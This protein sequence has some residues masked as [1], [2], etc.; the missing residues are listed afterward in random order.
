MD[1]FIPMTLSLVLIS[2]LWGKKLGFQNENPRVARM[3]ILA[4]K[5]KNGLFV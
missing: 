3:Y 5:G 4:D 2:T 1:R